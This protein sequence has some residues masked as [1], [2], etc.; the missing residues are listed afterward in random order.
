MA[1]W[2][3][4]GLIITAEHLLIA[5]AIGLPLVLW[6]ITFVETLRGSSL[7]TWPLQ[8]N[9]RV[10]L[11]RELRLVFA[12]APVNTVERIAF[13]PGRGKK[14]YIPKESFCHVYICCICRAA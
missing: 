13:A 8:P 2:G 11:V 1:P 6:L 9:S 5:L 7:T 3:P 10:R 12:R 4:E 14:R